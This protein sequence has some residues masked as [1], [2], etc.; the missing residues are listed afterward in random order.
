MRKLLL[1]LVTFS[2][3]L[4][5]VFAPIGANLSH[6]QGTSQRITLNVQQ[7]IAEAG[8]TVNSVTG[9]LTCSF[10]VDE[11]ASGLACGITWVITGIMLYVSQMIMVVLGNILD[12]AT[13]LT[14]AGHTYKQDVQG[15]VDQGWSIVRDITNIIFL[16]GLVVAALLLILNPIQSSIGGLGGDPKRMIVMIILMA[17]II[18]FSL[19]FTKVIIDLGNITGRVF[20]D[21]ITVTNTNTE[22]NNSDIDFVDEINNVNGS[23]IK[24][25]GLSI[26]SRVSPGKIM[27]KNQ[28]FITSLQTNYDNW[29]RLLIYI[30][31]AFVV[32]FLQ[33]G[34]GWIFVTVAFMF[35]A[36]TVK[37]WINMVVSPLAFVT[38][39]VPIKVLSRFNFSEWL[40]DTV[41]QS[42]MV[43]IF[44]FFM[45][46]GIIALDFNSFF[47]D[48]SSF[49]GGILSVMINLIAF[50][51]IVKQGKEIAESMAGD[52]GKAA[53]NIGAKL[54]G[55]GVGVAT[56]GAA[57]VGRNTLGRAGSALAKSDKLKDWQGSDNAFKAFAGRGLRGFGKKM[58]KSSYDVRN[59]KGFTGA[60]GGVGVELG[61]SF[62]ETRGFTEIR[63]DDEKK[64]QAEIAAEAAE[65]SSTEG[66]KLKRAVDD[67]KRDLANAKAKL[68]GKGNLTNEERAAV[69]IHKNLQAEVTEAET[70][71]NNSAEKIAADEAHK[72]QQD[73]RTETKGELA[74]EE[75]SEKAAKESLKA[76]D[77]RVAQ[78]KKDKAD[79]DAIT[80]KADG[81]RTAD[82][83]TKLAQLST[84]PHITDHAAKLTEAETTAR[85]ARTK[86][87]NINGD[88]SRLDEIRKEREKLQ[89][90][91]TEKRKAANEAKKNIVGDAKKNLDDFKKGNLAGFEE[92]GRTFA[93]FEKAVKGEIREAEQSVRDAERAVEEAEIKRLEGFARRIEGLNSFDTA[94]SDHTFDSGVIDGSSS[95]LEALGKVSGRAYERFTGSISG[96]RKGSEALRKEIADRKKRMQKREAAPKPAGDNKDDKGGKK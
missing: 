29:T 65:L 30:F 44:M 6:T 80:A 31:F 12:F 95:G 9:A 51:F 28:T 76:A 16:F 74:E 23:E 73:Y 4:G 15:F 14:L 93:E 67:E 17:L 1:G 57:A 58:D 68:E 71:Y 3:V 50:I 91:A 49:I 11:F 7:N 59:S 86:L 39:A 25:I 78:I 66:G 79:F 54:A 96:A 35:F 46:L 56:G 77:E 36:R 10:S 41:K 87:E 24:S 52:I 42:F 13:S 90:E 26:S 88:G 48:T 89:K 5:G 2:V 38:A 53:G 45:Y 92:Q 61:T 47:S 34:I 84:S 85:D 19:F 37:L 62:Q 81:D 75:K 60:L 83:R 69:D 33:L 43:A 72:K 20:Y 64:R 21:R 8:A 32:F 18:N 70:T 27:V 40:E 55:V 63:K 82:E 22:G 94:N